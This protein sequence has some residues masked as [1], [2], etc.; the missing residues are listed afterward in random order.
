M[1]ISVKIP[2]RRSLINFGAFSKRKICFQFFDDGKTPEQVAQMLPLAD[3]TIKRYYRTWKKQPRYFNLKYLLV[4]QLLRRMSLQEKNLVYEALAEHLG[5][6]TVEVVAQMAKP[7]A[8]RKLVTQQWQDWNVK[9]V[10]GNTLIG[11]FAKKLDMILHRS[12]EVR[13]VIDIAMGKST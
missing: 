11:D 3:L 2:K 8:L 12:D 7:W 6:E 1:N 10:R 9:T 5:C 4:R 13:R